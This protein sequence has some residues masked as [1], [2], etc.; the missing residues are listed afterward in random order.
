MDLAGAIG[1]TSAR[2]GGAQLLS[3]V[4][5]GCPSNARR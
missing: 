3:G 4:N 1:A 5:A 2:G